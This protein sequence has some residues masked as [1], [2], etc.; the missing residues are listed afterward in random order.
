MLVKSIGMYM[1]VLWF[2]SGGFARRHKLLRCRSAVGF[3]V[4][5][6]YLL[7]LFLVGL[8]V[9]RALCLNMIG[10]LLLTIVVVFAMFLC[11]G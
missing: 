9:P 6:H 10:F 8:S 3:F 7:A 1:S 5:T 4:C 11:C 2:T